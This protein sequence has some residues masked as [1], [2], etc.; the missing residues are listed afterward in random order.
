MRDLRLELHRDTTD[1]VDL[2]SSLSIHHNYTIKDNAMDD[3]PSIFFYPHFAQLDPLR[4]E[5]L[6][7]WSTLAAD[8][9]F[10]N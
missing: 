3:F 5:I 4:A 6:P 7:T 10:L 2:T 8:R 9:R 1:A